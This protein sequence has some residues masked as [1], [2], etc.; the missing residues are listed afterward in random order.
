ML[1]TLLILVAL[2]ARTDTVPADACAPH[3]IAQSA[4]V[5][6]FVVTPAVR[7]RD[8]L[9]TARVCVVT[10]APAKVA[11]YHGELYFDSAAVRV[12]SVLKTPR[13]M[14]AENTSIPGRVNFAGA[15]PAGFASGA[16]LSIVL[17]VKPGVRPKVRLKMLELNTTDGRS[18]IKELVTLPS[19]S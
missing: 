18:L 1:S 4:V 14:H 6:A 11:S 8:T 10:R 5:E 12:Q 13:G 16:L 3:K 9:V 17:R 19:S 7:G 15:E 2:A